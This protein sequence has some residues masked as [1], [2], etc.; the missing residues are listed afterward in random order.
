MGLAFSIFECK[1][2]SGR[3]NFVPDKFLGVMNG[4]LKFLTARKIL[5][6]LDLLA[7]FK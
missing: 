7:K 2:L 1:I 6:F 4:P 3:T 5:P